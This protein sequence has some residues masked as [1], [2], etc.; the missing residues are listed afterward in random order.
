M[1]IEFELEKLGLTKQESY[2]YLNAL[3]LGV[4][5]ASVIAQKCNMQRGAAYYTL[6]LLQEKGFISEATKGGVKYY[7]AVSPERI[8]ELIEENH[9]T[10][11]DTITNIMPVLK[12]LGDTALARPKIEVFEGLEGYKSVFYKILEKENQT[13]LCYVSA[14]ILKFLPNFNLQFRRRRKEKNI[15]IRTI[16]EPDSLLLEISKRNK[17]ELRDMRYMKN[18][19]SDT[20]ALY[21]I[22]DDAVVLIRA[23]EKEQIAVYVQEENLA[24]LHRN[25]FEMMWGLANKKP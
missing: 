3:K 7:N 16:S 4:S 25:I 21:Y 15:H 5:K 18:L 10:K 17:E 11:L 12:G 14:D 19:F 24:R 6:K 23:N 1:D 13:I 9:Q 2:V 22:L 8:V 20:E